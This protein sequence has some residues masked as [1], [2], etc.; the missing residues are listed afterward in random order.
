MELGVASSFHYDRYQ[1]GTKLQNQRDAGYEFLFRYPYAEIRPDYKSF[2]FSNP[3]LRIVDL[4][5]PP[6]LDGL[7]A[8]LERG[9]RAGSTRP[10]LSEPLLGEILGTLAQAPGGRSQALYDA[11]GSWSPLPGRSASSRWVQWPRPWVYDSMARPME[12]SRREW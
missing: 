12:A 4:R 9:L 1:L 6:D 3:V 5:Q 7:L 8:D 2:A 11:W 10:V